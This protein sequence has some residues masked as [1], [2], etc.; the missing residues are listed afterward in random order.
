MRIFISAILFL[1][2]LVF[3]FFSLS[4]NA[5]AELPRPTTANPTPFTGPGCRLTTTPSTVT[6][7]NKTIDI[8]IQGELVDGDAYAVKLNGRHI[9]DLVQSRGVGFISYYRADNKT[10]RVRNVNS[11]ANTNPRPADD[12][13][14]PP[15]NY[16]VVVERKDTRTS[17]CGKLTFAVSR[18]DAG[19]GVGDRACTIQ[20]QNSS[21]NSSTPIEF[22]IQTDDVSGDFFNPEGNRRVVVKK[23]GPTGQNRLIRCIKGAELRDTGTG[24]GKDKLGRFEG[25]KY[26]LEVQE[27]CG[28]ASRTLCW[29]RF[30][31]CPKCTNPGP[32]GTKPDAISSFTPKCTFIDKS[33]KPNPAKG[34]ECITAIGTINTNPDKLIGHLIALVLGIAGGV[35]VLLIIFSGYQMMVTGGNPE[36]LQEAKDRLTSAIVG[37][38][39]IIFSLALLRIIGIDILAIPGFKP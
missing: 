1:I 32:G 20:F 21:F 39:F 15:G 11:D 7:S 36:K 16:E 22:K 12:K 33:E 19:T 23:G 29:A 28:V 9:G 31:I 35:A 25:G 24:T 5:F 30:E 10:I 38:V 26:Y 14:F 8:I 37:L 4:E 27:N 3:P 6:P 13:P 2:I 34:Y 18:A 17:V